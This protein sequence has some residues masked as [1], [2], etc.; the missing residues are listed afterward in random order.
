MNTIAVDM[1]TSHLAIIAVPYFPYYTA[2]LT[3]HQQ[4]TASS[5]TLVSTL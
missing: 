5:L 1:T 4:T 2:V 3:H